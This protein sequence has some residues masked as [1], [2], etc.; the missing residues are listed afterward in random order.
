M[1]RC[2]LLLMAGWLLLAGPAAHADEILKESIFVRGQ[3]RTYYLF[4]PGVIDPAAPAPLLVLF[5]GSGRNGRSLVKKWQDLADQAGIIL[6]GPDSLDLKSW[7]KAEDGPD[8]IHQLVEALKAEYPV[9]A[10]RVYLF[11]HSAGAYMALCLALLESEYFAAAAMHAGNLRG[12]DKIYIAR[13][14]RKM[15][16]AMFVGT[17]DEFFPL[18][19]VRGTRDALNAQGFKVELTEIEGHTHWYY[20]RAP[21]INRSAWE[22]FKKHALPGAPKYE[23]PR[24]GK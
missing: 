4:V 16:I 10:R 6:V 21:E 14:R 7:K 17:N 3:E 1:K 2:A 24:F 13:A 11:G 18:P 23:L 15:P 8:F 20:D 22:F 9:D 12:E 5:H 19:L